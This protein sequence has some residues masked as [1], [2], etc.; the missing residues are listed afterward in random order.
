MLDGHRGGAKRARR[1]ALVPQREPTEQYPFQSWC[2]IRR[3]CN[4]CA[5]PCGGCV[6]ESAACIQTARPYQNKRI[7]CRSAAR[8]RTSRASDRADHARCPRSDLFLTGMAF[9]R[10]SLFFLGLLGTHVATLLILPL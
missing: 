8:I 9:G 1:K 4:R 2:E 5:G 3:V 10:P 6:P 7:A